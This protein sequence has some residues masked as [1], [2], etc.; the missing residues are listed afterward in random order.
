MRALSLYTFIHTYIHMISSGEMKGA[1]AN[2]ML[3]VWDLKTNQP[4]ANLRAGGVAG[5]TPR[6]RERARKRERARERER[7]NERMS[8]KERE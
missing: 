1:M 5:T 4:G 6:E 2:T 8:D 7:E 3:S